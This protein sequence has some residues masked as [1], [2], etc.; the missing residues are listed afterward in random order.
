MHKIIETV[1]QKMELPCWWVEAIAIEYTECREYA[2]CNEIWTFNFDQLSE[3]DLEEAARSRHVVVHGTLMHNISADVWSSRAIERLVSDIPVGLCEQPDDVIAEGLV[4]DYHFPFIG[5]PIDV[6]DPKLSF[7]S[8][9]Q[10]LD[11]GQFW[12]WHIADFVQVEGGHYG[13]WTS[14]EVDLEPLDQIHEKL[15]LLRNPVIKPGEPGHTDFKVE[16]EKF[17][18]WLNDLRRP[19]LDALWDI[20]VR[21]RRAQSSFP[22][23]TKRIPPQLSR[24]E[25]F[26]IRNGEIYTKFFAAPVF[27]RSCRQHAI[28][29]EKLVSSGDKQGSVAKIDEIYQERANAIILGAACLEAFIND[30]GFEHFPKLWK[31]IESLSLTAK[32]QLYLV[33]KGKDDLF[34]PG[35]EPYQSLAQLKKS[36]GKMMHFKGD[37]KKVRQMTNGVITHTEFDLPREFVRDLPNRLEQL[38]R[39]LCEA[40]AL[41]IPPW[42]TPKPNLGWM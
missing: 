19:I 16:V 32:W 27:F 33:L 25:S 3:Y 17:Y 24:F 4:S 28:E 18:Q 31:N 41:P 30:L 26:T 29:A 37:Y 12:Q 2:T 9:F 6:W 5:N 21:K 8:H 14:S 40:T 10:V 22:K 11:N 23:V 13:K 42:L 38:I 36:R 7:S 39:E 15:A 20:H 34:D 35:R 1:A